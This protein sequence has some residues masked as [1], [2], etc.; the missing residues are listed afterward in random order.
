MC[1]I[2]GA[3]NKRCVEL[4][5]SGKLRNSIALL[6]HRGPDSQGRDTLPGVALGHTRLSLL[7][8]SDRG[9]Q[10][11]WDESGRYAIVYNGEVYNFKGLRT[12]LQKQGVS[13]HTG[14]D[15]EVVLNALIHWNSEDA[16]RR[17]EGMFA[18][19][20]YDTEKETLLLA[21]DRHGIKPLAVYEDDDIFLFASE[22]KAFRPWVQL[23]PNV[24]N[25]ISGLFGFGGPTKDRCHYQGVTLVPPGSCITVTR[26]GWREH[27]TFI[28]LPDLINPEQ[29]ADLRQAGPDSVADRFEEI[30][31]HAIE[32][33]LVADAPVGALCS[34]GVDSSLILSIAARYKRDLAIFHANVVGQESEYEHAL[35]L[36]RHLGLDLNVVDLNDQDFVDTLPIVTYHYDH[37]VVYHPNSSP[38]MAVANLA[39]RTGVKAVLSGEGSDECFLGYQ[40]IAQEPVVNAYR[41]GIDALR[42]VIR[43]IPAVG[44]HLAPD[45][46]CPPRIAVSALSE[47]ER[48]MERDVLNAEYAARHGGRVDKNVK[49]LHWLSYHLRTLLHRNDVLGM[50]AGIEARF[51][52]LDNDLTDFAVNLPY[53]YKIRFSPG[54]LEKAHPFFRDKWIV[55]TVADRYLPKRLSRRKKFG[56]SVSAFARMSVNQ[57]YFGKDA[58]IAELLDLGTPEKEYLIEHSEPAFRVRLLLLELWGRVC[59]RNC[60][61]HA[62]TQDL[63]RH[64][65]LRATSSNTGD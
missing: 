6:G 53:S 57:E 9:R 50:A 24:P 13:F 27:S 61:L 4:P 38:F 65:S 26:S 51:P 21:R 40:S 7:D 19:G 17:F 20:L 36:S 29:E 58:F 48:E 55:R 28:A 30:L 18:L 44:R 5:D 2:I 42:R 10:P 35:A 33:M 47:F 11:L 62:A 1:G 37:P 43:A 23:R 63:R 8:L 41:R 39:R 46:P 60:P 45:L 31:H 56:F 15:T 12:E 54:T 64:V 32:E 49:T 59:L 34:G 16:L 52:Y 3:I 25:V 22:I 14:T